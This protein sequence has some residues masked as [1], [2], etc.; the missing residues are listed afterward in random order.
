MKKLLASAALVVC[1]FAAAVSNSWAAEEEKSSR[2]SSSQFMEKALSQLPE[3]KANVFRD[4]MKQA[5]EKNESLNAQVKAQ[6]EELRG[7]LAAQN[8]DKAAY[9]AKAKS[10]ENLKMQM[11]GA[12]SEAFANAAA[13][14]SQE[15]RKILADSMS[16]KRKKNPDGEKKDEA[17]GKE[18]SKR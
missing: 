8:F 15:E 6:K 1:L 18:N 3:K 13:N 5:Y 17:Y 12:R 2:K 7:L 14:L 16:R 10:I 4:T 11:Y 9:I